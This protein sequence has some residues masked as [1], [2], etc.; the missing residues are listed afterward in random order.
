[1]SRDAEVIVLAR[2]SDEVIEPLPQ[3]DP[4]RTWRGRFVPM[5]G[6]WGYEFGWAL[7][8]EKMRARKGFVVPTAYKRDRTIVEATHATVQSTAAVTSKCW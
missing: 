6:H 3:D 2:W 7:E 4:E 5:A 8:C 1:M